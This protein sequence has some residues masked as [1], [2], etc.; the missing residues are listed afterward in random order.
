M[1]CS[2][3]SAV[4]V[5][6]LVLPGRVETKLACI[7]L[8]AVVKLLNQRWWIPVSR[9]NSNM[10]TCISVTANF[11]R[12]HTHNTSF[13]KV[14]YHKSVKQKNDLVPWAHATA[15]WSLPAVQH[16]HWIHR[17]VRIP[18]LTAMSPNRKVPDLYFKVV[19]PKL[20]VVD[21][22]AEVGELRSGRI[23]SI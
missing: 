19:D 4:F 23:P 21:L 13:F 8:I 6:F 14:P 12:V 17:R 18:C 16:W 7:C 15:R 11:L 3:R 1:H 10:Y 22:R 9:R 2:K 20:Q 5:L